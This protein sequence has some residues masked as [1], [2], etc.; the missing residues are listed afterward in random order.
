MAANAI[1]PARSPTVFDTP[2]PCS[3][4]ADDHWLTACSDA[5]AQSIITIKSQNTRLLTS[6]RS[7]SACAPSACIG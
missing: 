7:D 6:V 3:A 4:K 1:G 5:P 2:S